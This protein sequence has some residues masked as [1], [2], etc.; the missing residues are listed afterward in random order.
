[1][2]FLLA[3]LALTGLAAC[4]DAPPEPAPPLEAKLYDHPHVTVQLVGDAQ[5]TVD[6]VVHGL[7]PNQFVRTIDLVDPA[8][9]HYPAHELRSASV[10][11]PRIV[12]AAPNFG[13]SVGSENAGAAA[14]MSFGYTYWE[15]PVYGEPQ[16][17]VA[18]QIPIPD[19]AAYRLDP[20][21]WAVE[22]IIATGGQPDT[23]AMIPAPPPVS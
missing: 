7:R 13:V 12:G 15:T 1:M 6:V 22:V 20:A 10:N 23:K 5:D 9:A 19:P 18:T 21:A 16:T 2:R 17:S 11:D 8:G 4:V 14:G 3:F